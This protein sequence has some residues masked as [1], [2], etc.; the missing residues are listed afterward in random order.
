MGVA[1]IRDTRALLEARG[2]SE[3]RGVPDSVL[4]AGS[5]PRVSLARRDASEEGE[6]DEVPR[7]TLV[8]A[9]GVRVP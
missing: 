9:P 5:G 1:C 6:G 3:L 2:D 4:D 7:R 8:L